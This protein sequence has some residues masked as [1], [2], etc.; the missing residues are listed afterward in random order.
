V[1]DP[2]LYRP[3]GPTERGLAL[4]APHLVASVYFGNAE[5]TVRAGSRIFPQFLH[6]VYV[7]LFAHVVGFLSFNRQKTFGT[8]EFCANVAFVLGRKHTATTIILA[9][10]HEF[11]GF[12]W[13]LVFHFSA[14]TVVFHIKFVDFCPMTGNFRHNF[15]QLHIG[16]RQLAITQGAFIVFGNLRNGS[17][18]QYFFAMVFVIGFHKGCI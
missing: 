7:F 4:N 16:F 12:S 10:H 15:F 8:R 6:C 17:V 14:N 13:S 9:L 11:A 3:L 2:L 18:R 1:N 5:S